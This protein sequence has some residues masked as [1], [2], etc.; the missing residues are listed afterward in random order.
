[1]FIVIL[2][3]VQ[4]TSSYD[5]LPKGALL[6]AHLDATV[7]VAVLLR[8]ALRHPALHIRVPAA[9]TLNTITSTTPEFRALRRVEWASHSESSITASTYTSG[10]WS[11]CKLQGRISPRSS[12]ARR[13]L[14]DGLLQL[15]LS[16]R[17]RLTGRIVPQQR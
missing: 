5:Q 3:V 8:L 14:I 4:L 15:L 10:E 16:A 2:R 13:V 9:L 1:M 12:V 11:P 7:N 6:H 17:P